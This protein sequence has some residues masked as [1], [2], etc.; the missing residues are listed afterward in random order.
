MACCTRIVEEQFWLSSL[1][2]SVQF[3]RP[4]CFQGL[5]AVEMS[6]ETQRAGRLL[7]QEQGS[8]GKLVCFLFSWSTE[9][10]LHH[11]TWQLSLSPR[12]AMDWG[13]FYTIALLTGCQQ[14]KNL[15]FAGSCD[16]FAARK[17]GSF[18]CIFMRIDR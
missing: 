5:M 10:L 15:C 1:R 4:T 6:P 18:L 7:F 16:Q 11:V 17:R 13:K 9:I 2:N 8:L 12:T 3:R 14:H